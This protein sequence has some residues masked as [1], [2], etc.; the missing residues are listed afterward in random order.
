MRYGYALFFTNTFCD[1]DGT[2]WTNEPTEVATHTFR[3]NDSR[4]AAGR[5]ERDGLM[6]T[7]TA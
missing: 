2:R 6:A 1:V 7:I 3:T 4:L 5:V